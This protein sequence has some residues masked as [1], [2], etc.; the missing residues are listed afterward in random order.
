MKNLNLSVRMLT[1]SLVFFF[2]AAFIP[3]EPIEITIDVAPAVLNLSNSGT[4]VTVHT[5][6]AY[7]AVVGA[8]VTLNGIAIDWWKSDSRGYFVAKF[9]I[10]EVKGIVAPGPCLLK[11][12][13]IT[14]T[15]EEFWGEQQITVIAGKK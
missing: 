15:G 3:A 5:D 1:L 2:S 11:M 14:K 9:D 7:G 4:V 8:T 6:I 12:E 10:N 13:G